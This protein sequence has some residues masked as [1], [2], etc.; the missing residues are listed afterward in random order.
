MALKLLLVDPNEKWLEEAGK[1]FK[2]NFY[3]VETALNG[4]E[5]QLSIYSK[6]YF[7]VIINYAT[8]SHS[9]IQVLKFCQKNKKKVKTI[10]IFNEEK[11][12]E[13][14]GFDEKG[15]K[16]IGAMDIICKPFE[17]DELRN[18]LEDHQ[19]LTD[20]LK[21]LKVKDGVS[22]EEEVTVV[23][24]EFTRVKID[25]FY[26][27]KAV[28]FDIFINISKNKYLKILHAGDKFDKERLDRYKNEKKVEFLYFHV[29]DR[30]KFIQYSNHVAKKAI[31]NKRVNPNVKVNLLKNLSEKYTE[32]TFT[33]G[34]K[35]QLVDEG[36]QV[37]EHIFKF[38][39]NEPDLHTLL[40]SYHEFDPAAIE[41][42]FLVTLYASAIVK[43]FEWQSQT[44]IETAAM[45]CMLHDIGKMELP[46]N[47]LALK[48]SDMNEDQLNK[49]KLHP[50]IGSKIVDNNRLLNN[51]IKQ[52]VLQH[53]EN[54]DGT[55]FPNG[56]K[57]AQILTIA[58]IVHLADDFAHMLIEEKKK[59][60]ECLKLILTN[61]Q[62]VARYNSAVT[63]NFIKVFV[64]PGKFNQEK[65]LPSNSRVVKTRK[66]G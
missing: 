12:L 16:K 2:E 65:A 7:A 50:E 10:L 34:L 21:N 17:W 30:R 33:Q 20:F 27:S 8:T 51:S 3:D 59:P 24:K 28:L 57:A 36:R 39:D 56:L 6:E 14:C 9:A 53:H 64:D 62:M 49:Y 18:L 60:T 19:D 44:T 31:D 43:Q 38:I 66:T 13:E 48:K 54:F 63:E 58:N 32:E 5:A 1:I 61:R 29:K 52:I 55:G 40:K 45:A 15:L 23:D 22:E 41:H 26:S 42:S 4:K 37:C 47:L 11:E 46:E 35:S 25:Q